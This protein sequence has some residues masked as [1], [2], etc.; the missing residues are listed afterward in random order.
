MLFKIF[1]G[2]L[3]IL[4]SF[5]YARIKS[6]EIRERIAFADGLISGF[7]A[8]E[9]Q[10]CGLL[11]PLERAVL[12]SA[13]LA[14]AAEKIFTTAADAQGGAY[15]R[16]QPAFGENSEFSDSVLPYISGITALEEEERR[17]AFSLIRAR[18]E[19]KRNLLSEEYSVLGKLYGAVGIPVGV[20]IVILLY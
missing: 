18:L 2:G 16:F 6:D 11:M 14:G 10:I 17:C 9:E 3:V 7:V 20:L 1:G 13:Q 19:E 5:L 4:S 8:L 15:E 12:S